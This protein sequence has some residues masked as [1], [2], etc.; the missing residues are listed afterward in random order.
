[1]IN[2]IN[3]IEITNEGK[4]TFTPIKVFEN[5][6]LSVEDYNYK[7]TVYE[8][9]FSKLEPNINYFIQISTVVTSLLRD[10]TLTL[11]SSE[12]RYSQSIKFPSKNIGNYSII[13]NSCLCWRTYER[14]NIPYNSPTIGNLILDDN[15]YLRFCEHIDTYFTTK[16]ILG[17]TKGNEEFKKITGVRRVNEVDRDVIEGY[18]ITHHLDIEI[19]WIHGRERDLIFDHGSYTELHGEIIP[20]ETF[21]EKWERRVERGKDTEKIFIWS[22]SELFNMHGKWERKQ[23]IDRFKSLPGKS[24]FLTE[25]KEEEYEDEN[26]IVKF[27]PE[28]EN[29]NQTERN[30]V[31]GLIWNDQLK[32]SKIIYDIILDKFLKND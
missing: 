26:H 19:H 4:I 21:V 30:E 24:I 27:I 32:N 5:V 2:P 6:H 14:F 13:G 17:D 15:E 10:S 7:G 12:F 1:M 8:T 25:I 16:P 9:F 31:G 18:P 3:I 22:S 20:K 23:I 28:W 29:R 11:N